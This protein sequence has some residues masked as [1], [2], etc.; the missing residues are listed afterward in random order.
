MILV[1]ASTYGKSGLTN[2]TFLALFNHWT[3]VFDSLTS[4]NT[5]LR[6]MTRGTIEVARL[7]EFLSRPLAVVDV[8]NANRLKVSRGVV[9]FQHVGFSYQ[10]GDQILKDISFTAHRGLIGVVGE[11]GSGKTT[12]LELLARF[13][14]PTFGSITIDGQDIRDVTL[15]SLHANVGMAMQVISPLV[16]YH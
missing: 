16:A 15:E 5:Y 14:D 11:N 10:T 8:K 7:A 3:K 12:M 2:S 9:E 13:G 6:G 1:L 4:L